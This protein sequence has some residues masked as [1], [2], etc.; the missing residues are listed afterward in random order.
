M[1]TIWLHNYCVLQSVIQ[2]GY[3]LV[4]QVAGN[5]YT[6]MIE[7]LSCTTTALR[8]SLNT[9]YADG[10][11]W[12]GREHRQREVRTKSSTIT[13]P[14]VSVTFDTGRNR[15]DNRCCLPN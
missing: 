7:I 11:V 15:L 14:F 12:H 10:G 1:V 4:T 6:L 2:C 13:S 8:G 9:K 3:N 5:S